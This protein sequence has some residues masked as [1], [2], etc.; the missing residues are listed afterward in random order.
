MLN[1]RLTFVKPSTTDKSVK[2]STTGKEKSRANILDQHISL[3][4]SPQMLPN[5]LNSFNVSHFQLK[6]F[7]RS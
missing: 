1:H 3:I 5:L 7:T 2:P 4:Y 6:Q